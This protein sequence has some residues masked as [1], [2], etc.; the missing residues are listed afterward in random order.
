MHISLV[1][2]L[3]AWPGDGY[4]MYG[5]EDQHCWLAVQ[6]QCSLLCCLDSGILEA[7]LVPMILFNIMYR[8]HTDETD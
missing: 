2:L 4:Q 1:V 7:V 8:C 5:E 3:V 6:G